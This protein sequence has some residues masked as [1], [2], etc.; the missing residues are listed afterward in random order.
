MEE[1]EENTSNP[2][3]SDGQF[4]R[5]RSTHMQWSDALKY[6][7]V[8]QVH[9]GAQMQRLSNSKECLLSFEQIC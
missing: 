5:H 7:Q 8:P 1:A 4:L 6:T 9:S 3:L 2:S